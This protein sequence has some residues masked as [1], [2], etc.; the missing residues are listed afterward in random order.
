MSMNAVKSMNMA[1]RYF[2]IIIVSFFIS[3]CSSDIEYNRDY[4]LAGDGLLYHSNSDKLYTGTVSDS[5]NM[6]LEYQ[7]VEGKKN[8]KFIVYYPDGTLAQSGYVIDNKNV[9][10]WKY[11]YT[12]GELECKG[13]FINDAPQGEWVFY[14][15]DGTLKS[16]GVFKEG[17]RH[18]LWFEYNDNGKLKLIYIFRYGRFVDIQNRKS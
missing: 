16:T 14:Y 9:G 3:S 7:V 8:G 2:F 4:R 18:G 15:P 13:K 12:N 17:Q 10:E 1:G 6:I 5:S 11:F